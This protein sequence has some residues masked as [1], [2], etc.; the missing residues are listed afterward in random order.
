V[1]IDKVL[2]V[3]NN[4]ISMNYYFMSYSINIIFFCTIKMLVLCWIIIRGI[5]L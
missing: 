5:L 1:D 3:K 4:I 2:C